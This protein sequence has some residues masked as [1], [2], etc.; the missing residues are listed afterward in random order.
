MKTYK[1]KV[2][3]KEYLVELEEVENAPAAT[4]AQPQ[5]ATPAT[6]SQTTAQGEVVKAPIQGTVFKLLK[7]PGDTVAAGDAVMIIE[8]MKM[9]NEIPAPR[10]GKITAIMVTTGQQVDNNA[11]DMNLIYLSRSPSA[12][13]WP[14]C[15]YPV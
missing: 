7:Q 10:A 11:A 6:S 14:T 12:C 4:A 2:N 1:V 13:F 3:G 8:A 15:L 5:A 9:E